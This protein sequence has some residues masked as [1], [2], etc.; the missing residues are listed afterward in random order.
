MTT[1]A[2]LV[3]D[4]QDHLYSHGQIRDGVTAL[5]GALTDSATSFAVDDGAVVRKGF[6]E[7]DDEIIEVRSSSSAGAVE[8]FAWGRGERGTTA[9]AHADGSKVTVNPLY[10]KVR[11]KRAINEVVRSLYPDLFAV[12]TVE[13]IA[14]TPGQ[15][16]YALPA[17][18]QRVIAVSYRLPGSSDYYVPV[19]RYKMLR[20]VDTATWT[21]GRV[22]EVYQG[23]PSGVD[24]RVVYAGEF[25]EFAD[26]ADTMADAGLAEAWTDIVRYGVLYRLLV[27][28]EGQ[29]LQMQSA[30]ASAR[31]GSAQPFQALSVSKHYLN[32]FTA[33]V[34]EERR[35]L[36]NQNPGRVIVEA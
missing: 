5:D 12:T 24:L 10:P 34:Q 2:D 21:T 6:V 15:V 30:E 7:I 20:N 27:A 1:F 18:C 9:V 33:R 35:M 14:Y 23:V 11:I 26:D 4:V 31:S 28:G 13:N 25:T 8:A 16:A 32:L 19:T 3:V 22:I 36:L 29:R 17:A